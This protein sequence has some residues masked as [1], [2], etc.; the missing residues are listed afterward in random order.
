MNL[1]KIEG[2][3]SGFRN[4]CS[5]RGVRRT[6]EAVRVSAD[7]TGESLSSCIGGIALNFRQDDFSGLDREKLRRRHPMLQF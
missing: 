7:E 6:G 4:S 2:D 1:P 3:R 5:E